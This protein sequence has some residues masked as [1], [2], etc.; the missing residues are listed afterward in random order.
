MANAVLDAR[1]EGEALLS[2]NLARVMSFV[3]A[4]RK[5]T[6]GPYPDWGRAGLL[7]SY[8]NDPNDG[9]RRAGIY[10]GKILKGARPRDLPIEQASKFRLVV[11]QETARELGIIVRPTLLALADEVIELGRRLSGFDPKRKS[12]A[13]R[14]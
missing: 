14:V 13:R 2:S 10:V 3:T 5:P 4:S 12:R 8:A 1:Q 6:V 9:V 7:M 11:N